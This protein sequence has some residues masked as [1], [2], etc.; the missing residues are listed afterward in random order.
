[1]TMTTLNGTVSAELIYTELVYLEMPS[2]WLIMHFVCVSSDAAI[3][4][5]AVGNT[6]GHPAR[7]QQQQRHQT[8]GYGAAMQTAA[9]TPFN[10]TAANPTSAPIGSRIPA[11]RGPQAPAAAPQ[12]QG[13]QSLAF[14]HGAPGAAPGS[15]KTQAPTSMDD[16]MIQGGRP[17][18]SAHKKRKSPEGTGQTLAQRQQQLKAKLQADMAAAGQGGVR[19]MQIRDVTT[20]FGGA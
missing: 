5:Q 14:Q 15:S 9:P 7:Q 3:Y 17:P 1:M 4:G 6:A 2:G 10:S 13:W 12:Q 8:S 20:A 16:I 19:S 11:Y 18:K